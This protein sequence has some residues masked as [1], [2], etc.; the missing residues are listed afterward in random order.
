MFRC[1]AAGM[2]AVE[3][4]SAHVFPRHTHDRYGIGVIQ[5]GGQK[6][7]SGRGAVEAVTGEMIA[8]NPGEMHD[9]SPL[10]EGGRAWRMLYF[11]PAQLAEALA[12]VTPGGVG[13]SEL[14]RP[15]VADAAGAARFNRLFATLTGASG[16]ERTGRAEELLL[17]IL[18]RLI[19]DPDETPAARSTPPPILSAKR[20][21]DED[22]TQR[23]SL[24]DL[25]RASGLTRF[26]VLRGFAKAT[27]FTPHGYLVQ[28]RIGMARRLI[29]AGTSLAEA[30]VSSGFA[31][32]SHMTRTFVR[33][34]GVSPGVYAEAV[35]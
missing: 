9:G 20:L 2:E 11:E 4:R 31:D 12:E 25:A 21:I 30:A 7:Q 32:Q 34:F 8:C 14:P 6:W 27:G 15:V 18:A 29:A 5:A 19:R 35:V 10:D 22:P 3:A 24:S 16:A 17:M 13:R 26:Q 28:R 23:L 33:A 1:A